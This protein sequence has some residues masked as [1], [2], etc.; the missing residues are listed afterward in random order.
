MI[1]GGE[2]LCRADISPHVLVVPCVPNQVKT[3]VDCKSSGV[4]V[5]WEPSQG[6]LSYTAVA[7]GR[8]GSAP[9]CNSNATTCL[10]NDL[11]C[12]SNYSITVLAS[13]DFCSSAATPAVQ[14]ATGEIKS[15]F[16]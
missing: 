6:A 14:T 2:I 5:S 7:Q 4:M 11:R 13:D 1:I 16:N 3:R 10:L 9:S 8:A 15:R 12:G